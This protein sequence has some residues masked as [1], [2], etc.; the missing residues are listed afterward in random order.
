[1][2]LLRLLRLSI[3]NYLLL[4]ARYFLLFTNYLTLF[5]TYEPPL[6]IVRCETN[7]CALRMAR[8]KEWDSAQLGELPAVF[9]L[10]QSNSERTP[11]ALSKRR[12]RGNP[13]ESLSFL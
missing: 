11:W 12:A 7:S 10:I 13:L 9:M 6:P 2:T 3:T 8:T 5:T 1:M 4:F